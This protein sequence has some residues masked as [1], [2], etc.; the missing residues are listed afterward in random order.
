VDSDLLYV[1]A[2][3]PGKDLGRSEGLNAGGLQYAIERV[4]ELGVL[5][6]NPEVCITKE[7]HGSVIIS[8][9]LKAD[10]IDW[11]WFLERAGFGNGV[12]MHAT[13]AKFSDASVFSDLYDQE[14]W[15]QYEAR[16][17]PGTCPQEDHIVHLTW[18]ATA[19]PFPPA[20]YERVRE[21]IEGGAAAEPRD[22][23]ED[24]HFSEIRSWRA[25]AS[26]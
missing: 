3:F 16:W 25:R 1:F 7:D 4:E 5:E 10:G 2:G 21:L 22:A 11:P 12:T 6:H 13:H 8:E 26:A 18:L 20:V 24:K 17:V 15:D 19:T 9:R 23:Y 14:G